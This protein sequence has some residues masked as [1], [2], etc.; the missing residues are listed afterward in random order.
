[1]EICLNNVQIKSDTATLIIDQWKVNDSESWALFCC[2]SSPLS[3]LIDVLT[4]ANHDL[5]VDGDVFCSRDIKQV[6]LRE[7]Q[8][9]LE[10]EIANDDTDYLDRVDHGR[11]VQ[12][13]VMESSVDTTRYEQLINELDL[14]SL[15]GV[16]FR[17]LSTGESRR[18]L[19]AKA[20]ASQPS[21]LILVDPFA[22]LDQEHRASLKDYLHT[23]HA[24]IPIICCFS[25]FEDI[26]DWVDKIA[27]FG[28]NTIQDIFSAD[29]WQTNDVVQN[30]INQSQRQTEQIQQALAKH[31]HKPD[32]NSTLFKIVDGHVAYSDKTIFTGLNWQ[33]DTHQH[34]QVKGPN[35]CGK[36]TLLGLIFG[37][38]PQ[39]YSNDIHIFGYQRGSGETIWEIKQQIGMVSSSLHLQYRV[40]CST[41]QAVISG[42]Y[43][44]IGLYSQPTKEQIKS[45]NEWLDIL[46][47]SEH[48][49]TPFRQLDYAQQR[50]VLLARALIK[51]PKLLIL[52][53]PYQGLDYL[54]RTLFMNAVQYLVKNSLCQVLYVSHYDEDKI[55]GIN[56]IL[57]FSFNETLKCYQ[58]TISQFDD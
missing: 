9:L 51:Q 40:S 53:E 56:N 1:M 20:L 33:I 8:L 36:S 57:S 5:D 50:L 58:A 16:G 42:Y 45:A 15:T 44:S 48:S 13:L 32:S 39:C 24:S 7:Q 17:A 29:E 49:N 12:H 41:L 37:D 52:D 27:L 31:R 18:V 11:T 46:H 55:E 6:S 10:E 26:P 19:I 22:G 25:R 14:T 34:W 21:G 54:G 28:N 38:H 35:G 4:D 23:Q 47:L 2:D 43:D 30:L 3:S